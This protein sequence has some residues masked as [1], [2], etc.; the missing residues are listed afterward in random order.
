MHLAGGLV[1]AHFHYFVAVT[2]VAVYEDA[3]IYLAAV[4]F[5]LLEHGIV[6]VLDPGVF[7]HATGPWVWATVHAVAILAQSAALFVYWR[8]SRAA[9][10]R[11]GSYRD[12]LYAGHDSVLSRQ[13]QLMRLRQDLVGTVSH[14]FRTPLTG[15]R[16]TLQLLQRHGDR[17]PAQQQA[18]LLSRGL[19]AADRLGRLIDNML[20]AAQ[21]DR[22]ECLD[23]APVA[24]VAGDAA[25]AVR[26]AHTGRRPRISISVGPDLAVRVPWTPLRH[27]LTN[28]LDN[29]IVHGRPD[30]PVRLAAW[31]DDDWAIVTISNET[32]RLDESR[33]GELFEP[34]GRADTS[35]TREREGAGMGLYVV[36]RLVEH[37]GGTVAA[38]LDGGSL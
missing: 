32:G 5:V 2:L 20:A 25:D 29:A 16:G 19:A 12:Q 18:E 13:E 37:Y 33:L 15:I 36:R 17:L 11:E 23:S 3:S 10:R 14:K 6:G 7:T 30:R 27:V 35:T 38:Q 9:R 1:E 31:R 26:A 4:A 8:Y 22:G 34:F 21:P 28:L 24:A